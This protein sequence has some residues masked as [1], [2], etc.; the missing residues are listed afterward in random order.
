MHKV[1]TFAISGRSHGRQPYSQLIGDVD[2]HTRT[3]DLLLLV[4]GTYH[5]TKAPPLL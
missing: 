3:H 1:L 5:H 4:E 2:F